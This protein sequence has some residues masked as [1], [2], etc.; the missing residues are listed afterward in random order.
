[1]LLLLQQKII[2]YVFGLLKEIF[3][4]CVVI[5]STAAWFLFG[6]AVVVTAPPL[7]Y[8]HKVIAHFCKRLPTQ[9]YHGKVREVRSLNMYSTKLTIEL[10]GGRGTQTLSGS[11]DDVEIG[12]V[13]TFERQGCILLFTTT[14]SEGE[15]IKG[16]RLCFF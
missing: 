2:P 10:E 15:V 13:F 6:A 12:N 8:F 1:M 5:C 7:Q 9:I 11:F 14:D 3:M 16:E 4:L